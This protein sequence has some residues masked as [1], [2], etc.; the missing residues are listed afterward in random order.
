[1]FNLTIAGMGKKGALVLSWNIIKCFCTLVVTAERLEDKL[2]ERYFNNLSSASGVKAPRL[3]P[4][5]IPGPL[6]GDL[7]PRP[8]ICPSLWNK[9]CGRPCFSDNHFLSLFAWTP[10]DL[11]KRGHLLPPTENVV[12]CFCALLVTAK[13][14][15]DKLFERYFH[16]LS[17]A[18]P[19]SH[20]DSSLDPSGGPTSPDP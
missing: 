14:L 3:P 7:R 18:S 17:S 2:F 8:L 20:R 5:S 11:G 16:N 10:A 19:E 15:E 1:M 4:G 13:R 9:S 12:K 6:W